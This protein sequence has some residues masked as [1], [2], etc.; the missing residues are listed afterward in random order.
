MAP[1]PPSA[2]RPGKERGADAAFESKKK[3]DKH[4]TKKNQRWHEIFPQHFSIDNQFVYNV[5][6]SIDFQSFK[7][8][9][10]NLEFFNEY[11]LALLFFNV[12]LQLK[13]LI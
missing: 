6:G 3:Q 9:S 7:E 5:F 11:F 10:I 8:F 12:K 13:K 2:P 1:G 4:K